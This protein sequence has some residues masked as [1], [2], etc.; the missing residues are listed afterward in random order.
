M[1]REIMLE[2][3]SKGIFVQ[4]RIQGVG[5]PA[6][7]SGVTPWIASC[8]AAREQNARNGR[9]GNSRSCIN[10]DTALQSFEELTVTMDMRGRSNCPKTLDGRSCIRATISQHIRPFCKSVELAGCAPLQL[11]ATDQ[12]ESSFA[13]AAT[14]WTGMRCLQNTC[15]FPSATACWLHYV[16]GGFQRPDCASL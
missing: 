1:A 16:A 10:D 6:S 13:A 3:A 2:L 15:S 8:P 12:L 11:L 4:K 7:C 14:R 9:F 5:L